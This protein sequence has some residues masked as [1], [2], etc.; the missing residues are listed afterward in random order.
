MLAYLTIL[1]VSVTGYLGMSSW[2][3]GVA[4]LILS[5]SSYVEHR[6]LR[7][8][9]AGSR[10]FAADRVTVL[11]IGNAIAATSVAYLVGWALRCVSP[12]S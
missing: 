11:S 6:E 12:V 7:E 9:V 4:A 10:H 1:L 3:V 2:V 5:S 8:R